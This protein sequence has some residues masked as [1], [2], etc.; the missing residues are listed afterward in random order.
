MTEHMAVLKV[1]DSKKKS[2]NIY[3][4]NFETKILRPFQELTPGLSMIACGP[5]TLI[6]LIKQSKLKRLRKV[7]HMQRRRTSNQASCGNLQ[8]LEKT[9]PYTSDRLDNN[10]ASCNVT[11][12]PTFLHTRS[13]STNHTLKPQPITTPALDISESNNSSTHL[14][15][16]QRIHCETHQ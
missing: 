11:A 3:T 13:L 2:D 4:F 15:Q 12:H 10:S 6:G 5:Y 1:G 14:F 7:N 9:I 16:L 8:V